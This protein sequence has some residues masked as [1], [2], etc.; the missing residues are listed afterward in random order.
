M[1]ESATAPE[2]Y[3]R[4]ETALPAAPIRSR[5]VKIMD[6]L[7]ERLKLARIAVSGC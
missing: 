5:N 4:L 7:S 6:L 1:S 2:K 3:E